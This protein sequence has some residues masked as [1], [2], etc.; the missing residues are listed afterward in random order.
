MIVEDGHLAA[1][2][3]G[4]PGE[5]DEC[6]RDVALPEVHDHVGQANDLDRAELGLRLG[7]V[8]R[9]RV[10]GTGACSR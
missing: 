5:W 6:G 7:V 2:G 1:N 10:E 8:E 9:Q 3:D 4:A